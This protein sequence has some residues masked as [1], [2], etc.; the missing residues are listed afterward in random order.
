MKAVVLVLSVVCM[1]GGMVLGAIV[2]YHV[3]LSAAPAFMT[4]WWIAYS[5]MAAGWLLTV[6]A[7]IGD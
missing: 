2:S 6:I 3:T 5:V 7:K 4:M 1:I